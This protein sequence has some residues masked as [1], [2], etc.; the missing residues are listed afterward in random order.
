M[1]ML[2]VI[3]QISAKMGP[4]GLDLGIGHDLRDEM[5]F[6][7]V[8]LAVWLVYLMACLVFRIRIVKRVSVVKA[9][10]IEV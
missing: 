2:D 10:E 7:H 9:V 6:E 1:F 4:G 3:A 5:R 8:V